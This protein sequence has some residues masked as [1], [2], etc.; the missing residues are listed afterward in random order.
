MKRWIRNNEL[1][2]IN[3]WLASWRRSC[4][5]LIGIIG[6][7]A[8]R[9]SAGRCWGFVCTV[10]CGTLSG[11]PD[12]VQQYKVIGAVIYNIIDNYICIYYMGLLQYKMSKHNNRFE[13]TKFNNCYELGIPEIL[14]NIMSCH[15]FYKSSTPLYSVSTMTNDL[16]R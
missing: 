2:N 5:V 15:G 3:E 6:W 8:E 10:W 1:I 7:R 12:V 11:N 4:V 13:D 14:I 16:E 9:W